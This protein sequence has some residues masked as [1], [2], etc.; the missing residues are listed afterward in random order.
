MVIRSWNLFHGNAV[1][2]DR[3]SHLEEMVRLAG[4]DGPD[5]LLLQELPLWAL[6]R[7]GTWSG[8]AAVTD[9]ARAP[10]FGPLPITAG[11]G[12]VLTSLHQ[13]VLRSAFTGQGMAVLLAAGLRATTHDVVVLNPR[14][15]RRR[16]ARDLDLDVVE[17][18]AWAKERRICQVVR[19]E[20]DAAGSFLI[21]NLHATGSG[22]GRIPAAEIERA[23]SRVEMVAGE[24]EA[25]VL[26]G[27]FNVERPSLPGYSEP[28][29]GIDQVLVRGARP[30]PLRTWPDERRRVAGILLSDH[31]P[32]ELE[33]NLT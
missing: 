33:L 11:L 9:V 20:Q 12:R 26:G 30:S 2:P 25:V 22:N 32:V 4:A 7:V 28:G 16:V 10:R 6:P 8:M 21:A 18:L 3:R 23:R 15:V 5:V 24:S 14:D 31:A 17:R 27:D 1:P 13:G 29:P 19:V